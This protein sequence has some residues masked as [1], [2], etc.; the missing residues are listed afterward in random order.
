LV[1]LNLRTPVLGASL[2]EKKFVHTFH[3]IFSYSRISYSRISIWTFFSL[4]V[5]WQF[6][7]KKI[8]C[9]S[10]FETFEIKKNKHGSSSSIPDPTPAFYFG[11]DFSPFLYRMCKEWT[12]KNY[13][14]LLLLILCLRFLRIYCIFYGSLSYFLPHSFKLKIRTFI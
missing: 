12:F 6:K 9:T 7:K 10:N 4:D 3:P 2:Q 5:S 8:I 11:Y 1:E 13:F 14:K